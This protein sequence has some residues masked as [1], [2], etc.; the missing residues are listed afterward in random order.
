MGGLCFLHFVRSSARRTHANR[1]FIFSIF[2]P[3]Q[4]IVY[5]INFNSATLSVLD[6]LI[7]RTEGVLKFGLA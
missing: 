3:M 5:L 7:N 6:I 1:L 4:Y 2:F